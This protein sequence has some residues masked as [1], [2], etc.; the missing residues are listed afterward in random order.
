MVEELIYATSLLIMGLTICL[1]F[2][3]A[4]S[5]VWP[6]SSYSKEAN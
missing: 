4:S 5:L 1:M 6:Y 3:I 2:I